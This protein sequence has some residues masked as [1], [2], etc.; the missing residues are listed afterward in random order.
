MK[1]RPPL[2][3]AAAA[4]ASAW[5]ALYS[6]VL[7]I[8]LFSRRPIHEDVRMTYVAAEAGLRYG[9]STI[10]DENT[11]RALSA[12]F[13]AAD[14]AIDPVLTYLN[15][16]LLAWLFAP[17]TAF[18]EPVAY[19]LW[20]LVSLAALAFAWW[21]A[22]PYEGIAK[23]ALLLLAIALWPVMLVFY[24]GQPNML[25]I[26]SLAGSWWL[27]KHDRPYLAGGALALATFLKPQDVALVPLVL[28]VSGRYRTV[29]GWL[30][31]CA[32]MG[33][34]TVATLQGAGLSS[35]WQALQLGSGMATHAEYT[36]AHLFG[37][38]ALTYG[39]WAL[40]GA[41]ALL[42]AWRR[43]SE[44]EVVVA[45]GILGTTALAFHFH[46]LDYSMLV[47]AAW[48]FLRSSPPVWQRVVL[49]PGIVT[50]QVMT[51]GPQTTQ[52]VWDVAT[53]APQLVWDA[54]WLAVLVAGSVSRQPASVPASPR[55]ASDAAV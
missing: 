38:T 36:L 34:L 6:A 13:P 17:L 28:L 21:I 16:P 52:A 35:W 51:Y 8:Y 14:R 11:L 25:V 54:S 24:F 49:L 32:V 7:W 3:L 10:Y 22:A 4:L 27:L 48:L 43:R 46:E 23:V 15:P 55:V 30:G 29:A 31:A 39:L 18:S 9:W 20:T 45:A 44:L 33:I 26:A 5:G 1:K 42:V 19:V 47:L 41:A 40:Q 53:H 12:G 50:M 2:W 37:F